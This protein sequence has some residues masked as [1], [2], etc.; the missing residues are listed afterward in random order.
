M[1]RAPKKVGVGKLKAGC[2]Q[3]YVNLINMQKQQF[4]QMKRNYTQQNTQL[5][6]SNSLQMVKISDLE[7]RI[8]ELVQENVQL[9]SRLSMT[10]VRS[11]ERLNWCFGV[12]EQ[13]VFQRFDEVLKIFSGLREEQGLGKANGKVL[14][15]V[16][17]QCEGNRMLSGKLVEF[18]IPKG[19]LVGSTERWSGD[20]I[21]LSGDEVVP[22]RKKRRK[23]S[24]RESLFIPSDFD[25]SNESQENGVKDFGSPEKTRSPGDS[26]ER[27]IISEEKTLALENENGC[28]ED[29]EMLNKNNNMIEDGPVS[30]SAVFSLHDENN[31]QDDNAS[32]KN[33]NDDQLDETGNFT[34]SII[35]YF[36]PEERGSDE[37][38]HSGNTSNSRI[39]VYRD[40]SS[41]DSTSKNGLES[42][43]ESTS[44]QPSFVQIPVLS[45]S[46]I[47]HS[48]KPPRSTPRKRVIDEG[49]PQNGYS[50]STRQRRTRGKAVDYKWP[51]LRAKMRRPTA[52]L[53]DATTVTDIHDLQV[54]TRRKLRK[55][56]DA[57]DMTDNEQQLSSVSNENSNHE[58]CDKR[59]S[60][61][62]KDH[63]TKDTLPIPV[64]AKET[65]SP[66]RK[67]MI[68]K[69]I[70]NK[71]PV[72]QK[73][74]KLLSKRP[75]IDDIND[76]NSYYHEESS[77]TS[78]RLNED[79]F[80]VFDLISDIKSSKITKTHRAKARA[81]KYTS[82][83]VSMNDS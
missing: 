36:I 25:F 17:E 48:M 24:R 72:I 41:C 42:Y 29:E 55:A 23:S 71:Q 39:E 14:D 27:D 66:R 51:S 45:Q 50:N 38:E 77:K 80:S 65:Q 75:I 35:E 28:R 53:V 2:D 21:E 79:D 34:H 60:L 3:E 13:G 54:T 67:P 32:R 11:K 37:P 56:K 6:K 81:E 64:E 58:I 70:T 12:L 62:F 69:D 22:M 8:S 9:R 59:P 40:A 44:L 47:K 33:Q 76:E 10:D 31:D 83:K 4:E 57:M 61:D 43:H 15:R 82:K 73:T 46:K 16:S 49:M 20:T 1:T 52:E 74:K 18:N 5:A 30:E 7:S 26:V 68:L 78:F 19:S 63:A